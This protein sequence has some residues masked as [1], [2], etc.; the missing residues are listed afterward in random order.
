MRIEELP[1]PGTY[2]ITPELIPDP[3][4]SFYEAMRGDLLEEATGVP[5]LPRQINYSVSRRHTLRGI[6]SVRIPPGQAKYVTCVRGALRDIVV[7]L[8][9]GSPTF[10]EHRVNV[11]DADS[12]RSVYVPEGV[13]HGFLALT[14]DACIC[15]VVSS[16]YVPGTQIDINPLDPDL[17]LPWDCPAPP[18]IS[19]K[20][21][22][23]P[24]VA[25]AVR[26]GLLPRF[27]KAGTP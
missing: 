9:I 10:G 23:A 13:G 11:L 2:V 4:G 15:Y 7:D 18:L 8:R 19:D 1:L 5:F 12:G 26:A 17:G 27:D 24:T 20:D 14:D 3:R 25:E 22:K 6:H 21:A 16:T